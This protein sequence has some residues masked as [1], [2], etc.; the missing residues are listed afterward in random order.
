MTDRDG[1]FRHVG[2]NGWL[3]IGVQVTLHPPDGGEFQLLKQGN[4][5]TTNDAKCSLIPADA[6]RDFQRTELNH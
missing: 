4:L 5:L 6:R 3:Y 2:E 1:G